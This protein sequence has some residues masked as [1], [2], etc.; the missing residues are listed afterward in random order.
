MQKENPTGRDIKVGMF[1]VSVNPTFSGIVKFTMLGLR[2]NSVIVSTADGDKE[3]RV[4]LD[5][6]V[7]TVDLL[8][9][10]R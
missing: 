4:P 3:F 5:H 6:E 9:A 2:H 7:Q 10:L 1:V 8:A